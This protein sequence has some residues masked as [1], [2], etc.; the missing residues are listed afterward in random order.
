MCRV[1]CQQLPIL[2]LGPRGCRGVSG[3]LSKVLELTSQEDPRLS[4]R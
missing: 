4:G 3:V 1:V 2:E